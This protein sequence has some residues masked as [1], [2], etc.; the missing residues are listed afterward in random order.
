MTTL[1]GTARATT[2]PAD[3]QT[4]ASGLAGPV[5]N[6]TVP[7]PDSLPTWREARVVLTV[8]PS[9]LALPYA[10]EALAGA[11][12]AWTSAASELPEVY[13]VDASTVPAT[14]D[15]GAPPPDHRLSYAPEGEARA[16][17]ALAITL[18]T[19]D[20]DAKTIVD[21]DIV[22]NGGHRFTD[23]TTFG[24][25]KAGI[26]GNYY[27]LQNVVTHELGHWF[28][29]AENYDNA[30]ATMFAYVDPGEIKKR[31]LDTQDITQVQLAYWQADNPSRHTGCSV[32][33]AIRPTETG[34]PGYLAVSVLLL[35]GANR[36]SVPHVLARLR[37]QLTT[38]T[39][40]G[41]GQLRRNDSSG[42]SW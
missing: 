8:D 25:S 1:T 11:V 40:D 35:I 20:D 33:G 32:T 5:V 14:L 7:S 39:R 38:K 13:V 15:G 24:S 34:L 2:T 18:L 41:R 29:L 10:R 31:D 16:N 27:D 30:E 4:D 6:G 17:G 9:Y 37:R 36:R 23:V 42:R 19:V 12:A 22:I 3:A 21:G 26:N 28:G